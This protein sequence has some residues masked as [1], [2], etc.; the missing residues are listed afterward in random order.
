MLKVLPFLLVS[1]KGELQ[2]QEKK[3]LGQIFELILSDRTLSTG[4]ESKSFHLSV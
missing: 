2:V 3:F 1:E 4:V